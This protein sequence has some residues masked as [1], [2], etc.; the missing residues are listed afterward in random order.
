M[1]PEIER[2]KANLA[3]NASSHSNEFDRFEE[4]GTLCAIIGSHCVSA[5]EAAWRGDR[6]LAHV[7]LR[8]ARE[9]LILALKLSKD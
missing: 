6:V 8:H 7:H 1:T 5:N 3:S 4:L 9:A 2:H